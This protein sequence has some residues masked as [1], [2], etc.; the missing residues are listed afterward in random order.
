MRDADETIERLLVGLRDAEP[1]AGMQRRVLMAMEAR[2]PVAS[3][4][5]WR[6]LISPWLLR[7]AIAM[8]LACAV[9][10]LIV[11]I[12]VHQPRHAPADVRSHATRADVRQ[13]AGPEAVAQQAPIVPRRVASPGSLR[14]PGEVSAVPETQAASFPAPPLPLTEQE[15]LLLRLA[16]RR[17]PEDT[18][19]LNPA[20][21]AAQSA[22]AT[23]QFQQFFGIDATQMRSQIE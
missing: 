1:S 2:E 8:S 10:S 18:A 21:Q 19:I 6:R 17:D 20:V 16:H 5:P 22:K 14:R 9:A 11:A 13:T 4:S 15:R 7:P 12:T 3:D 23:E